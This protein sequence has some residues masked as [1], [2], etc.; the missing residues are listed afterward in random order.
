MALFQL[1]IVTFCS[2]FYTLPEDDNHYQLMDELA[3]FILVLF[4][5]EK[6]TCSLP[7]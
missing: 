6:Y 4:F 2:I 3:Y 1:S 7:I 5:C